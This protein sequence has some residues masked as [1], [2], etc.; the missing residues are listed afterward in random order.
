MQ[1]TLSNTALTIADE[2]R[3]A[4][5]SI[6]VAT[7]DVAQILVT[8]IDATHAHGLS[9]AMT[10]R[11]VKATIGALNALAEGQNQLAMNAHPQMERVGRRLGLSETSWGESLP[12]P[13][14]A[15]HEIADKADA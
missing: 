14:N 5:H 6:N 10:H 9:A 15:I 7:R 12:K 13:S 11:A 2:L 1:S 8:T 4:E 3:R